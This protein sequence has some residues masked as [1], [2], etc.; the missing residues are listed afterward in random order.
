MSEPG[1]VIRWSRVQKYI[2]TTQPVCDVWES[3]PARYY[4]TSN[5]HHRANREHLHIP[6]PDAA[7]T[8][9]AIGEPTWQKP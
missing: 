2:I 3:R 1:K 8:Y 9:T 7:K 6:Q 4:Q 5:K